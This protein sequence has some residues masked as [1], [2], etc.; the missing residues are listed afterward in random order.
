MEWLET[1]ECS[2]SI[3]EMHVASL[4]CE[5]TLL[6]WR[7]PD[8]SDF[9]YPARLQCWCPHSWTTYPPV[10]IS[11]DQDQFE[12]RWH[13]LLWHMSWPTAACSVTWTVTSEQ[14]RQDPVGETM[15]L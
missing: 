12:V 9:L 1:R 10:E 2:T 7:K 4:T 13:R 6:E 8:Q 11:L 3:Q 15:D 5:T 14:M